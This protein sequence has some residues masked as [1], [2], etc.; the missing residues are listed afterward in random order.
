VLNILV[1]VQ[2]A[3]LYVFLS[4]D[5]GCQVGFYDVSC[6]WLSVGGDG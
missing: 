2:E 5:M 6:V 4:F 3:I 1:C